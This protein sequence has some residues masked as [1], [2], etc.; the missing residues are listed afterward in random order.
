MCRSPVA[1]DVQVDQAVA[2]DLVQHMVEEGNAGVQFLNAG[3]IQVE[4]N[5]DLR[6]VGI[7]RDV[8]GAGHGKL[9]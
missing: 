7:A 6:F 8:C 2:R 5:A 1:C 4:G 9:L 3:A